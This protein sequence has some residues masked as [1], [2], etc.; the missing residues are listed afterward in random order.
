VLLGQVSPGLDTYYF[1]RDL[2]HYT[3]YS[4]YLIFSL[5]DSKLKVDVFL[6]RCVFLPGRMYPEGCF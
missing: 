5:L 2:T 1:S 6:T 3:S 4:G